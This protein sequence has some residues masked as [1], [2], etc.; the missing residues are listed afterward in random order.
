MLLLLGLGRCQGFPLVISQPA[1]SIL[2]VSLMSSQVDPPKSRIRPLPPV[3]VTS[4]IALMSAPTQEDTHAN[5]LLQNRLR[6]SLLTVASITAPQT[7]LPAYSNILDLA[8][9]EHE[10]GFPSDEPNGP[11]IPEP[12]RY[13]YIFPP[14]PEIQMPAN[15][16]QVL[17]P[18]DARGD[19]SR[20]RGPSQDPNQQRPNFVQHRLYLKKSS[21]ETWATLSFVSRVPLPDVKS[22][23]PRFFGED[24][25]PGTLELEL[26]TPISVRS[27]TL[28]V[29]PNISYFQILPGF[30]SPGER[31]NDNEALCG[32]IEFPESRLCHPGLFARIVF[33]KGSRGSWTVWKMH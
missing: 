17:Q 29:G 4:S 28:N 27:L 33:K 3:L 31:R 8:V 11:L 10:V 13:S 24:S 19:N 18:L 26:D 5:S 14:S 22:Q 6:E 32:S 2:S 25:V 30:L 15:S 1:A 16:T 21:G 12:P 9:V 20:C 7:A 23:A